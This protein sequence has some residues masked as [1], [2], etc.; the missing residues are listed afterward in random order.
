M[1]SGLLYSSSNL[2]W[3]KLEMT[4]ALRSCHVVLL[5]L[6]A[7]LVHAADCSYRNPVLPGD[8]PDPSIIRVGHDYYAT[9]TETGWGPLFSI[10]H[11]DDLVRWKMVGAV[12]DVPPNWSVANYWAP[13]L[14]HHRNRFY[15]YYT[16]R[17][18][19]GPF[20]VAAATREAPAVPYTDRGPIRWQVVGSI[21]AA[22]FADH[23]GQRYL[24]WQVDGNRR[25]VP[26]VDWM[27]RLSPDGL[28]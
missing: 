1:T 15:V 3:S 4:R 2:L 13:E 12:F 5:L 11:S 22:H 19:D 23:D 21:D 24:I 25:R 16:A 17:K 9:A 20:C 28:N 10:A 14:V 7:A 26:S 18:K 8:F 27:Q 6:S